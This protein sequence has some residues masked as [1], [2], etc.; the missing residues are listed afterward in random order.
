MSNN[1]LTKRDEIIEQYPDATFLFLDPDNF[2]K[3]IIGV[4]EPRGGDDPL[5]VYD[6]RMIVELLMEDG[7]DEIEAQEYYEYNISGAWMGKQT[8][9]YVW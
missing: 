5:I 8:P 3:A 2:D 7:M 1:S 6:G 9:L 4:S